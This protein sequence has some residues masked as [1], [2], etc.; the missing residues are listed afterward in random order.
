MPRIG[1]KNV[2]GKR[3]REARERQGMTQEQAVARV[4][5]KGFRIDQPGWARLEAGSRPVY[6]YELPILAEVLRV[7]PHWLLNWT[8]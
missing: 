1:H 4:Q 5:T 8:G 7:T 6:D 3:V 2:I